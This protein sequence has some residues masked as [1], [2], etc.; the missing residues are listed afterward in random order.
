MWSSIKY[1]TTGLTLT[2]FLAGVAFLV[3]RSLIDRSKRLIETAPPEHRASLVADAIKRYKIAGSENLTEDQ[4]YK[5]LRRELEV[6]QHTIR[7]IFRLVTLGVM[8]GMLF[9]GFAWWEACHPVIDRVTI[10]GIVV[11]DQGPLAG[12]TV[13]VEGRDFYAQSGHDGAFLGNITG[14]TPGDILT[15]QISAKAHRQETRQVQAHDSGVNLYTVTL[16]K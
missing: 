14:V 6:R 11:D 1:V 12:A 2:A 15:I 13:T 8:S 10:A 5:L 9:G 7:S 4:K 3:L 16:S